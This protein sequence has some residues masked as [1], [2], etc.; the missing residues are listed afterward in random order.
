MPKW[1]VHIKAT[2]RKTISGIDAAT[3]EEAIE[4]AHSLFTVVPEE[5]VEEDYD[6]E[7]EDVERIDEPDASEEDAETEIAA[8]QDDE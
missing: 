5:G 4:M 3:E 7:T 8:E 6:E 2:V 1:N